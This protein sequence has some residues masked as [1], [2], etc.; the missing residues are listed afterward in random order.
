M[1]I[2]EI[3]LLVNQKI[4]ENYTGD[5]TAEDVNRIM[6]ETLDHLGTTE[7][8]AIQMASKVI[9]DSN[10]DKIEIKVNAIMACLADLV[11]KIVFHSGVPYQLPT[12]LRNALALTKYSTPTQRAICG[13]CVCGEVICGQ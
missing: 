1:T 12:E 11:T 13:E 10:S 5:I 3:K 4:I 9:E 8:N 7:E 6:T 2:E